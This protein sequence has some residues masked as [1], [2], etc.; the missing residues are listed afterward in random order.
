[1][2]NDNDAKSENDGRIA[3]KITD[4]EKDI[5]EYLFCDVNNLLYW[6]MLRNDGDVTF[7]TTY[8]NITARAMYKSSKE[9]AHVCQNLFV[10]L[11]FTCVCSIQF[12]TLIQYSLHWENFL[13]SVLNLLEVLSK[14]ERCLK[15]QNCKY[16]L[17]GRHLL[18]FMSLRR[19]CYEQQQM[20]FLT[21]PDETFDGVKFSDDGLSFEVVV[22]LS[23]SSFD[24]LSKLLFVLV[25]SNI[26]LFMKY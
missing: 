3:T 25:L 21:I 12:S 26:G 18:I 9:S 4:F 5:F 20:L 6:N 1:M 8:F 19:L 16:I 24:D 17:N 10:L 14:F 15:R 11:L 23:T 2:G 7:A 22:N 13:W